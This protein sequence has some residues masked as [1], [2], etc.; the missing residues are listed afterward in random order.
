MGEKFQRSRRTGK[1][2]PSRTDYD[3]EQGEGWEREETLPVIGR[4]V[5][6]RGKWEIHHIV[7][8]KFLGSITLPR[9]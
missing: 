8:R 3:R 4:S 6:G 7:R 2:E 9:L 5:A 1:K